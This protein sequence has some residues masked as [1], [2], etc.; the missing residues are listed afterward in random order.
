M[1]PASGGVPWSPWLA[2][3]FGAGFFGWAAGLR[4]LDPR[5]A[6]WV[7][8]GD[9]QTHF[10]GWHMFRHEAWQWP[11]GLITK[12]LEPDGTAL[13]FT[14]AIPLVAFA[15]RPVASWLPNPFQYLGLWLW[16]CFALQGFFGALL[17]S[18]W[19]PRRPLQLLGGLLFVLMPTL[20]ARFAHPALCAHW[21]LL[22]ALWLYWRPPSA[23]AR[24]DGLGQVGL[25]LTSALVHPYLAVMVMAVLFALAWRRVRYREGMWSQAVVAFVLATSGVAF[26]WWASGFFTLP[27]AAD[28]A[29]TGGANSMNLLSLVNPGHLPTLFVRGYPAVSMSQLGEGYQY[30]GVGLL[31]IC[32]VAGAMAVVLR[33]PLGPSLP[34]LVVLLALAVFSVL[35]VVAVGRR[36]LLEVSPLENFAMFSVFRSTG[37]FFWPPAYALV[38]AAI[39]V[40]VT[41]LQART[42]G[43][44]LSVALALQIA[45]LQP[46][47]L[48]IHDGT[49]LGASF[50]WD[51]RLTSP[52]WS[53][54][55]PAYRH[56]VLFYP[57]RCGEPVA[58]PMA[59]ATYLAGL[60]GIGI[61]DGFAARLPAARD[62]EACRR[63]HEDFEQANLDGD[64][65]YLLTPALADAL[66]LRL[67]SGVSCR[68][69]DGVGVCV[70][71]V[72]PALDALPN[73]GTAPS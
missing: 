19:T 48:G 39:G 34:V 8:R 12:L 46:F 59:A 50:A 22:W 9:W 24:R 20:P 42:A 2:A 73:Q 28:M 47:W 29:A 67:G 60:Y 72:F 37:R 3:S 27:S 30:L 51:V 26:G 33:R 7:M 40:V 63:L 1:R 68:A 61:N 55:L 13:G 62:R 31:A 70:V 41:R 18:T 16:L 25:G 23:N 43:L 66:Q 44:V 52:E 5:E 65:V 32:V 15:L 4:V 11:P 57:E 21:L 58:A 14:D 69:I 54:L 64:T 36:V 17:V 53:R 56:M 35:P 6:G 71:G 38:A 10:L 49:R 45:D